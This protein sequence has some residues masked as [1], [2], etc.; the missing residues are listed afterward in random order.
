MAIF[1]TQAGKEWAMSWFHE[2]AVAGGYAASKTG[3]TSSF[4]ASATAPAAAAVCDE[5][6][7]RNFA[8]IDAELQKL[9]HYSFPPTLA[10]PGRIYKKSDDLAKALVF[11]ASRLGLYWDDTIH[12]PYEIDAFKGTKLGTMVYK[13]GLLVSMVKP[14]RAKKSTSS[15]SA[16]A[17]S[18]TAAQPQNTYKQSGGHKD[19][20]RDHIGLNGSFEKVY[21]NSQFIYKIEGESTTSKTNIP[22]VFVKPI[23]K[24]AE[25]NGTNKVYFG[26]GNGYTDCTCFFD[27]LTD[28]DNFLA[29]ISSSGKVPANISNLKV[30]KKYADKNGYFIV[31]TEFGPCAIQAKKLNEALEEDIVE[32]PPRK[33][34]WNAALAG[35]SE[36]E[37]KE[38]YQFAKRD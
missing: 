32:T 36:D 20:I 9:S 15:T 25:I 16:S 19:E 6:I 29:T 11:A 34:D 1:T 31:G 28:A 13:Y 33:Q 5:L 14:A 27:E 4:D 3:R 2:I 21:A 35:M 26:S 18:Q 38:F 24:G 10:G 8:D 7:E 17:G 37:L 23:T 22:T 30:V 12:T